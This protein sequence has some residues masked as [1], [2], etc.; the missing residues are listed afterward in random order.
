MNPFLQQIASVY[1]REHEQDLG[2]M[3]FVFP[4]RRAGL[5][6]LNYLSKGI[7]RPL[8]APATMTINELFSQLSS[9][10]TA[11]RISMLFRLYDIYRRLSNKPDETFDKFVYW[12]EM[13]LNDFDD[14]DKYMADA[15]QLFTNVTELKQLDS[16]FD[17]LSPNQIEAIRRFWSSFVAS[18]ESAKQKDFRATWEIL[19]P[20]YEQLRTNLIA[21]GE[22]YEGMI[23]REVAER[24]QRRERVEVEWSRIVFVGFNALTPAEEILFTYFRNNGLADFYW[25]YSIPELE[26]TVNRGGDFR[27]GNLER[28]KSLY[29]LD[30]AEDAS[31][32]IELSGIPSAVGQTK[33][34]HHLLRQM[35]PEGEE[36]SSEQLMKTAVILADENLLLP[37][38]H[39]IP[40]EIDK[41]NVTMGYPLSITPAAALIDNLF[42]L[43]RTVRMQAGKSLFYYRDVQIVLQHPYVLQHATKEAKLILDNISRYNKIYLSAD[44]LGGNELLS[45][46]FSLQAT[47]RSMTA[48][49]SEILRLLQSSLPSGEEILPSVELEQEFL[50][51]CYV[52]VNRIDGLLSQSD[53]DL[54]N[55]TFARLLK[56]LIAGIS[57]PFEGEPLAGLQI[58]GLLETRGLDF[59]NI[60]ITSLNEGV[61]PQKQSAPSFIPYHLR[62]GFGLPTGEH[63][64]AIFAYHFYRL[65]HRAKR[66]VCMYDTRSEGLQSGE[67][68]RYIHQLRYHYRYPI[69]EKIA[70]FDIGFRNPDTVVV[71][72]TADILHKLQPFLTEDSKRAL[73]ASAINTYL[74]CPLKFYLSNV[75]GL[76]ESDEVEETIAA[77]TFGSIFH[78]AMEEIYRPMQG[79]M[80]SADAIDNVLK[81][82]TVINDAVALSFTRNFL[83]REEGVVSPEGQHLLTTG[84]IQKYIEQLLRH[85]KAHA[86]FEYVASEFRFDQCFDLPSGKRVNLK[87]F[88][89]RIDR[90]EGTTRILDY[91]TGS[92]DLNFKGIDQ[93]FDRAEKKR[94]KAILQTFMYALLYLQ[95]HGNCVV[96]PGIV[97]IRALFKDSDTQI[98]YKPDRQSDPVTDFNTY[99]ADFSTAFATCLDEIFDSAVPFSQTQNTD[100]CKYCPF[101]VIC[102]R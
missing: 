81:S 25:D 93:L 50:Y 57:I 51:H 38:L 27:I 91:K 101:T 76:Q 73:S 80:V 40:A 98:K 41:V 2:N 59:E 31:R 77:S 9:L 89:D 22:G 60:I 102:K 1:V 52:A 29:S 18:A 65:I 17:Y 30:D 20:V 15:R 67:V 36:F 90:K 66:I 46:V 44:E 58:M 82:H 84:I 45:L 34:V 4:T 32:Q 23:F 95:Q 14:V 13:L 75:E 37:M 55:D 78:G 87:G 71:E 53:T 33:Y 21:D 16:L 74:D 62:K 42:V 68:S 5:F 54:T 69:E 24:M 79:R 99:K 26:D 11:D 70:T 92:Q 88:I 43:Q 35:Y 49:L 7:S 85:D 72:K 94:P 61:F 96:E 64:D 56:Q 6:F 47:P 28:F 12:G 48:Y 97:A 100:L 8:F 19:Y 10:Q 39:S 63:Q 86:P 3:L 83:R